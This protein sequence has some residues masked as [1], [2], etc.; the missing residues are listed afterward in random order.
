MRQKRWPFIPSRVVAAAGNIVT[1]QPR[2]RNGQ[3]RRHIE[4]GGK[5]IE[6]I[7]NVSEAGLAEIDQIHFIDRQNNMFN[8]Q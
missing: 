3:R 7:D 5:A 2:Y 8:A 1:G 4:I 6:I